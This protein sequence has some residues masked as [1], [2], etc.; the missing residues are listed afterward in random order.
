MRPGIEPRMSSASLALDEA[1]RPG[2]KRALLVAFVTIFLDLLGFGVMIPIAPFYAEHFGASPTAVT[3][4][5]A[6]YSVMQFLFAPLWGRLSDRIG[7]RPVVLISISFACAAYVITGIAGSFAV[8]MVSRALAGFGNANLGTVQAIIA[9]VT[10]P[11]DRAKGMG[12]IGAAFGLGFIF[13]PVL[14]GVVGGA[15]GAPAAAFVTSG[16]LSV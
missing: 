3:M 7:R 16:P 6:I 10:L 2:S 1:A 12:L 11:K 14:G 13:G 4:L 5:S 8:L 15:Y 9:D